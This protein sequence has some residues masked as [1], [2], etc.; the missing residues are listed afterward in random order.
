MQ[1]S[2]MWTSQMWWYLARSGG[3]VA[4]VLL[5]CSMVWGLLLSTKLFGRRPRPAWLLDLHRFLGG[6]GLVFTGVHVL[7]LMLDSYVH[8]GPV[9]ILVPFA[10]SWQPAAVAWGVID[11]YLLAA[12]ELTS[13]LRSRLPRSLWRATHFLSFPLFG[14]STLHALTA[15]TDAGTTAWQML[16][17]LLGATVLGLIAARQVRRSAR[18]AAAGAREAT[19]RQV[20]VQAGSR[21]RG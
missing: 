1:A 8:F 6:L 14:F 19:L 9:E 2:S 5:A 16:M 10:S 13:L 3:I 20:R 17:A 18:R 15:G 11:L 21:R 12:V 4:W 7:G